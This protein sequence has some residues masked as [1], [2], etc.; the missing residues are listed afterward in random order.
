MPGPQVA[1]PC[2]ARRWIVALGLV[3]FLVALAPAVALAHGEK[4]D[5]SGSSG[6]GASGGPFAALNVNLLS[7]LPLADIGGDG[8]GIR[9]NDIWGWTDSQTGKEYALV[10]RTDGTSFVDVSDPLNPIYLGI[11][12]THTGVTAWRDMKVYSDHMY[13]VSDLNAAHGMQIFDLT[14]LRGLSGPPVTFSETA[15]YSGFTRAHNL[16]INEDTGY[17]YV[18][19]S[20]TFGGGLHFID[21][22][23]PASPVAAGGYSG[24][25]YTHD[26][27]VVN[28]QGPDTDYTG[29]EIAFSS[30]EDTITIT[31]VSSKV[32]PSLI[33]KQG[34]AAANYVHQGWL[35][36]DHRYFLSNDELDERNGTVATT[37]T[38]MWDLLDLD[39]PVY[40]GTYDHGTASIDH[41]LYIKDGIAYEGNYTTGMRL[42]DTS[43][44]GIGQLETIGWIDTHPSKDSATSFDGVWSV[45]PF[46]DSGTILIGDRNEGLVV[47]EV[48]VVEGD[49]DLDGDVDISGDILVALSNFTGPN[50]ASPAAPFNKLRS[51]GDI[52]PGLAGDGD[53]D[54]ADLLTM[55]AAFTG[56]LDEGAGEGGLGG[57]AEAGDPAI[58]DLIYDA[59]T[60]EV[61]LDADG[62]SI[63]GY[64]LHNATNSFLPG[65]H[66]PIL[67]GVTTALTS[68]LEEAALAPGS[69]SIG[70]VFPAGLDL[71]GLQALLTVNQVSRSLGAPLVPFDLVVL[72]AGPPV[73]EPATWTL[74]ALGMGSLGV[75]SLLRRRRRRA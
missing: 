28:Y 21:L 33:S 73:P 24:D 35:T 75:F 61:T 71:A 46:F 57:P 18:V 48:D 34:Y 10:G 55:F 3:F 36:E 6:G 1:N 56:P 47:V 13:V 26:T 41:N 43:A 65:N 11:L 38:H 69:G 49:V 27:Q 32:S 15:H 60:G 72:S 37:V 31:D 58:P 42:V 70:L 2:A 12:P 16:A 50:P 63:I 4:G 22:T 44:V 5:I 8:S 40:L 53:V 64:S 17:A 20:N 51:E 7:H 9:G 66:T 30:N 59:A 54:V 25:G 39:N 52:G 62:S 45:Y 68:Q 14:T 23:N 74:A 19:G 29:A 67:A